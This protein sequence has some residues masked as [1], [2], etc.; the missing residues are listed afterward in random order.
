M[1]E[2]DWIA[3]KVEWGFSLEPSKDD[4]AEWIVQNQIIN[5]VFSQQNHHLE[6]IQRADNVLKVL[7]KS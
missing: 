7:S 1:K 6:L 3:S 5:L 4:F 2:I